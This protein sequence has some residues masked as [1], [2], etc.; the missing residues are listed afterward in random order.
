MFRLE[1]SQYLIGLGALPLLAVA[2]IFLLGWKKKTTTRMGDP[3][4]IRQLI[5]NF[6]PLRFMTKA[7]IAILAFGI[8]ILAASNPQKPGAMQNI[9]RKGVDVMFVLDV[10]KSM[11][12]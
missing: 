3:A 5:R 12:A 2:L 10:S 7:V 4:L 8:I 1:H 6:S 9:Q 11:L